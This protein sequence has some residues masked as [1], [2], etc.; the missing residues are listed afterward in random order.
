[1]TRYEVIGDKKVRIV[2]E[3]TETLEFA[4]QVA[5]EKDATDEDNA[6]AVLNLSSLVDRFFEWKEKLPR[7]EPFYAVKC[8]NDPILLK[9][10]ADLGAGFD[11]AS[12]GEVDAILENKLVDPS[13]IIYANPC[14]TRSFIQHAVNRDVNLMTFD[15]EEELLKIVALHQKPE[16]VL[17]IKAADTT[18][19]CQLSAK[20]GCEPSDEAP[21]LLKRAAEL[22]I[23]IVGISFHVGSGCHDP[24]AFQPAIE[25]ARR[26]FD[27]GSSF[28]HQ[29]N[30]LD[31]GGG[32]PGYDTQLFDKIVSVIKPCLDE[33]FPPTPGL[34]IIAEPGR[35]F[36]SAPMSIIANVISAVQ[37]PASRIDENNKSPE[38]AYMYYI[39]DG[40]YGS[41]N[42]LLFDHYHPSGQPLFE[43]ENG[44]CK[45]FLST[46]WGPTCDALDCVE[47][48]THLR[49]LEIGD[50]LYYP[51]M[52]AYTAVAASNF[53]GFDTPKTI[54]F[55]DE[56]TWNAIYNT[57]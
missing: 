53:N 50:W 54:H 16:M 19:Q 18:A 45:H 1:M 5:K 48:S 36:A 28:G 13:R 20:Y 52:G 56:V 25:H 17:R 55:M 39:N 57:D 42:C 23:Q 6:F 14:K 7:I 46:V 27:I 4:R 35:Y 30:L 38:H 47:R 21:R 49:R 29:M 2:S 43:D 3:N 44:Q 51:N 22:S 34:K 41:F 33:Y 15:N 8:N 10:L 40:V 32:F 11:C 37:V 12:K 26:L 24:S 9:V 31:I